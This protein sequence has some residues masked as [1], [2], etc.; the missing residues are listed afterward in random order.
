MAKCWRPLFHTPSNRIRRK[1]DLSRLSTKGRSRMPNWRMLPGLPTVCAAAARNAC[2][3]T[4]T[5][6]A[7]V[8]LRVDCFQ[9]ESIFCHPHHHHP[10]VATGFPVWNPPP[11]TLMSPASIT[12]FACD[13]SYVSL[14]PSSYFFHSHQPHK[15]LYAARIFIHIKNIEL[16]LRLIILKW[17]PK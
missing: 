11:S 13:I 15:Y 14:H 7:A 8:P 12:S 3:P 1:T 10:I 9:I 6:M 4:A 17:V 5:S 16:W 2:R